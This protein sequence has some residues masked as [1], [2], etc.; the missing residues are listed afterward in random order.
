MTRDILYFTKPGNQNTAMVIDCVKR[1]IETGQDIQHV[2][3]A[4]SRGKTAL[5]CIKLLNGLDI[6]LSIVTLHAGF[7]EPG[8][9]EMTNDMIK[10]IRDSGADLVIGPHS[11]SGI[12]RSISNKFGGTSPVEIIGHTL[13]TFCGHGLKVAVEIAI[14]A[15]D[16]GVLPV[17]RPIISI[18]GSHGGADTAVVMKSA[19]MNNFFDM[20]IREILAKPL[21][22]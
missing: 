7:K 1:R 12:S 4:S 5:K 3:V 14:M 18:G 9:I 17:D 6:K 2:V 15:S 10:Q 16:A 20:E 13:R 11:L 22:G 8:K 21:Q 19:H